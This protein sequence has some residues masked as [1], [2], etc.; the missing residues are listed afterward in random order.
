M[1][2]KNSCRLFLFCFSL[3]LTCSFASPVW[4]IN[5]NDIL[6][7]LNDEL[8]TCKN[9]M[10]E[11]D[12]QAKLQLAHLEDNKKLLENR[13][14]DLAAAEERLKQEFAN[15]SELMDRTVLTGWQL[16][17]EMND[18]IHVP[19]Q[20]FVTMDL[21]LDRR[22]AA[23]AQSKAELEALEGGKHEF[24]IAGVGMI[25]RNALQERIQAQDKAILELKERMEQGAFVIHHP[26]YGLVDRARLQKNA[27]LL[28]ERIDKTR[29]EIKAGDY[30]VVLPHLGPTSRN[31]LKGDMERFKTEAAELKKNFKAGLVA[32]MRSDLN[33]G[34]GAA[35]QEWA[36]EK[37]VQEHLDNLR[38]LLADVK[39]QLKSGTYE[40]VLPLGK[41]SKAGLREQVSALNVEI[42]GIEKQLNDK[43]FQVALP[44]GTW[45]NEREL[46]K[47]L[48][49]ALLAPDIRK[50]LEKGRKSITVSAK[51]EM[52]LRSMEKAKLEQWMKDFDSY[53]K[54][55]LDLLTTE[56]EWKK[57]MLREFATE[58][59]NALDVISGKLRWM[60][61]YLK[62]IP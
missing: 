51:A 25:S 3:C 19:R 42:E 7:P 40:F 20:G 36:D 16:I 12:R 2:A 6:M 10:Q 41:V 4:G 38:K 54:P 9:A 17:Q 23:R 60:E 14:Q 30:V 37:A 47:A 56:I 32:I 18:M 5:A 61:R 58:Q 45:A 1:R 57:K 62:E 59:K 52:L 15:R 55:H 24:P 46:D 11:L 48:V 33:L 44:D 39:G 35:S 22:E 26:T 50:G 31:K 29:A 13:L 43:S 21:L 27:E 34:D 49:N 53:V 8:Q 28:Q